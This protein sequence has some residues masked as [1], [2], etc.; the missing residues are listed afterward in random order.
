MDEKTENYKRNKVRLIPA[1][2]LMMFLASACSS[3][4]AGANTIRDTVGSEG[5][6]I[7][8][9]NNE[10]TRIFSNAY[11]MVAA[12]EETLK[13]IDELIEGLQRMPDKLE[14][15]APIGGDVE[16]RNYY[17]ADGLLT[18]DFTN[19]YREVD[20]VR[21]ILL[22]AA[23]VRTLTQI[24]AV[25][26]VMF[27][28]DGTPLTDLKGNDVGHMTADTFIYNAGSEIN[29]YERVQLTL[30]FA[31]E[32]G[33]GLLPVYRTVVYN[34]NITMERLIVDQLIAG[35]KSNKTFPVISPQTGVNTVSVRDNICYVDF[36]NAFLVQ[37]YPVSAE[38]SLYAIVN[39]LVEL[40]GVNKV[41]ISVDGVTAIDY[42]ETIN[43]THVLERNLDIV[44]R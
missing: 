24:P 13:A 44:T 8:Y 21:E 10:E 43:L 37:P 20:P 38:V 4:G 11:E 35:P 30:Y 41:Q 34:S 36:N 22:R 19:D 6:A 31:N 12:P 9:V 23:I 18:M 42:M 7:Y 14:Y 28:V 25:E 17:F 39:S 16:I 33:T 26:R 5:Y 29:A 3:S 1:L 40:P 27:L 15:E 32:E 2:L